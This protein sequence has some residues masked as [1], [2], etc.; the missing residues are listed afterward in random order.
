MTDKKCDCDNSAKSK[1]ETTKHD[2]S[3]LA[4]LIREVKK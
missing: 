4:E 1:P 3:G 2:N